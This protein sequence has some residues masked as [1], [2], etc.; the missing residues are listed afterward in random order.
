VIC[1]R[2]GCDNELP[3]SGGRPRKWCSQRCRKVALYSYPCA[4]GALCTLDRK[5]TGPVRCF[6]CSTVARTRWTREAVIT[7]IHRWADEHGGVPPVASD[8]NATIAADRGKPVRG[9]AF[10]PLGRVQQ[11][12]GSWA[13]AIEAAGFQPYTAGSYGREGEDPAIVAETIRLYR[14]EHLSLSQVADRMGVT[15]Q[16]I[17]HRLVVSDVPRRSYETA[18]A[19]RWG[20]GVAA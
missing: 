11:V 19:L 5:R 10:P 8:W 6:S 9:D 3:P 15:P 17:R 13:A 2:P 14:D 7:A 16:A 18:Q 12:F 1:A 20:S 4:C